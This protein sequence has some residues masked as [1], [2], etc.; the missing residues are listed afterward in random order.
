MIFLSVFVL[1]I[2]KGSE[3]R[4]RVRRDRGAI[5]LA[6]LPWDEA[7]WALGL[8]D[9]L[10]DQP[11]L[12]GVTDDLGVGLQIHLFQQAGPVGADGFCTQ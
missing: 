12:K 7:K 9:E 6:I 5:Y 3:Q 4:S 11:V 8:A 10:L 1:Q 2:G